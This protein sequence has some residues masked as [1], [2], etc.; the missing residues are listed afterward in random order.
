MTLGLN[1]IHYILKLKPNFNYQHRHMYKL[2]SPVIMA[3]PYLHMLAGLTGEI[4][5]TSPAW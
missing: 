1:Y 2:I 3:G 5:A 4:T